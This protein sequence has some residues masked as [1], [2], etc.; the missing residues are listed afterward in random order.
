MSRWRPIFLAATILLMPAPSLAKGKMLHW[1]RAKSV[2]K[3]PAAAA[4]K[5]T[6]VSSSYARKVDQSSESKTTSVK[7]ESAVIE[8]STDTTDE[9]GFVAPAGALY[10][11]SDD[12]G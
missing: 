4:T 3:A 8:D 2:I 11:N 12:V 7:T 9:D 6:L 10:T 1:S 5:H